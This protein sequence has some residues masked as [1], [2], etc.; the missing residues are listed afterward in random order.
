MCHFLPV[1]YLGIVFLGR[2]ERQNITFIRKLFFKIP[3]V[4]FSSRSSPPSSHIFYRIIYK[5]NDGWK[6]KKNHL[7]YSNKILLRRRPSLYV[8]L[9]P[10]NYYLNFSYYLCVVGH[11]DMCAS[12][13]HTDAFFIFS[14]QR[15]LH[16]SLK[17]FQNP[18]RTI[19]WSISW[20]QT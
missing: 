11:L 18:K 2:V 10:A 17:K 7:N 19:L 6:H 13:Y 14:T 9:W 1:Y 12:R 15:A 16:N 5:D 8:T 4:E 3:H 20:S